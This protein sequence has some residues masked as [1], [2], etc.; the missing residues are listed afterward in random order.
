MVF[1]NDCKI[2]LIDKT[3]ASSPTQREKFWMTRLK[4]LATYGLN[5]EECV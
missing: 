5:V 2:T 4:T 1:L 3:D